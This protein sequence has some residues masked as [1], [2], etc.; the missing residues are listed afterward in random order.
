MRTTLT[1]HR[2]FGA[3]HLCLLRD[4]NAHRLHVNLYRISATLLDAAWEQLNA[5]DLAL[6]AIAAELDGR[7]LEQMM[8]GASP[9]PVGLASWIM[10]RLSGG[11]PKLFRVEVQEGTNASVAVERDVR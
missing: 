5:L 11:F 10:E 9:E 2:E 3:S 8:P 6:S 1:A 4:P 7:Q